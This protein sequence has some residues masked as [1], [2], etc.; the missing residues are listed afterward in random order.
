MPNVMTATSLLLAV[1]LV[2][3]RRQ[4]LEIV[5]WN[6]DATTLDALCMH[7]TNKTDW[8][9]TFLTSSEVMSNST[10]FINSEW[11]DRK[12]MKYGVDVMPYVIITK[13]E[14]LAFF[15]Q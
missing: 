7:I 15:T 14:F 6:D 11:M 1:Y 5:R 3:P 8:N 13:S 4:M 2:I 9:P 12:R 10:N